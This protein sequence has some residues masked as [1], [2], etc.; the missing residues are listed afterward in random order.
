MVAI[1]TFTVQ[2][3]G[4]KALTDEEAAA[5]GDKLRAV[6]VEFD[7]RPIVTLA[8]VEWVEDDYD[9]DYDP[10]YV[11]AEPGC[12]CITASGAEYYGG[13]SWTYTD[14]E[15]CPLHGDEGA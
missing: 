3:M 5:L 12:T 11:P 4:W 15:G 7:P 1:T 2:V 6:A 9:S 10:D 13:R 14:S 8:G